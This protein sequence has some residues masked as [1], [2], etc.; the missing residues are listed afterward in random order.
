[1]DLEECFR[2]GLIKKTIVNKELVKSLIEMSN[3]R[4]SVIKTANIT[5]SDVSIYV[6]LAYDSLREVLEALCV[7]NGYKVLSHTCVGSFLKSIIKDFDYDSFD[8][9]RWIRNGI[10]YYGKRVDFEQGKEV[11]NKIFVM[12]GGIL[13]DYLKNI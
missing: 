3:T 12:K 2:K 5:K 7:L 11:I 1:M 10:N 9:F 13:K 8:R 6:S 4:E